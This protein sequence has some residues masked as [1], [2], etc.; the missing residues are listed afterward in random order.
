MSRLG[1]NVLTFKGQLP[2]SLNHVVG[3]GVK[4]LIFGG[5]ISVNYVGCFG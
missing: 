1:L 5:L 2:L 4:A 3:K